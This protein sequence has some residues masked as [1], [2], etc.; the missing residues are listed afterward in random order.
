[1]GQ[2]DFFACLLDLQTTPRAGLQAL[3]HLA[4]LAREAGRDPRVHLHSKDGE[5][6]TTKEVF[7]AALDDDERRLLGDDPPLSSADRAWSRHYLPEPLGNVLARHLH[8]P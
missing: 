4:A 2:R 7:Q 5:R 6:R 3:Q 1:M 8:K